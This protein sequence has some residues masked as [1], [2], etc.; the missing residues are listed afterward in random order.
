MAIFI[1][2][3]LHYSIILEKNVFFLDASHLEYSLEEESGSNSVEQEFTLDVPS[4]SYLNQRY[5]GEIYIPVTLFNSSLAPFQVLVKFLKESSGL[6]NSEIS[7]RLG[8]DI[9]AVWATYNQVKGKRL[10]TIKESRFSIPL[11]FFKKYHLSVLESVSMFLK[12]TGLS[13]ADISR[14]TGKDQRTIWTVCLRA[15]KKLVGRENDN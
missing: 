1:N 12:N 14:L 15:R 11:S 2:N 5:S 10:G 8:R 9:K 3:Y 4:S 6:S 7:S 13:Y